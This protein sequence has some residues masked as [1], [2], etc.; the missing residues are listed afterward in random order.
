[1]AKDRDKKKVAGKLAPVE[2]SKEADSAEGLAVM[3]E[4][5]VTKYLQT[6]ATQKTM[7]DGLEGTIAKQLRTATQRRMAIDQR[8]V[9]LR[10]ELDKHANEAMRAQ[11]EI[12]AH[13]RLLVFAEDDR[14]SKGEK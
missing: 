3:N 1:M 8:I 13:T 7:P 12:D 9:Q 10:K 2:D 5:D 14:R 11:G 6:L 4:E